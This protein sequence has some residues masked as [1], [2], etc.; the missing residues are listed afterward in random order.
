MGEKIV[1]VGN[2]ES[3][4]GTDPKTFVFCN[5]RA[6]HE[7]NKRYSWLRKKRARFFGVENDR[8]ER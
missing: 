6:V 3:L 7:K 8:G 5:E 4:Y 1:C 2:G